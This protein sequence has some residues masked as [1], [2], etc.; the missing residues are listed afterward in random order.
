MATANLS[1]LYAD[2]AGFAA[3]TVVGGIVASITDTS[4]TPPTAV[5]QTVAAGTASVSFPNVAA[6]SYSFS[7]QAV[8]GSTPPVPLGSAVTG[9]FTITAPATI[10]LSLPSGVTPTQS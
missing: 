8:D 9:T 5:T 1:I 6:G 3:G 7:V 10:S 2:V 4:V